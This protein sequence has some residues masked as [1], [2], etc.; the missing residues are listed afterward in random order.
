MRMRVLVMAGVTLLI[1]GALFFLYSIMRSPATP[2]TDFHS[3]PSVTTPTP[4]TTASPTPTAKPSGPKT[5]TPTATPAP[6][7]TPAMGTLTVESDVPDTSVFLDRVFLG[8]APVTAPDV[9][10]GP[11]T[12]NLSAA[13][14]DGITESV[15][16]AP[17]ART[18]SIKFKEVKL[19]ATLAVLH[20]H[21]IGSCS[22]TLH[23]TPQGLTYDTANKDDAFTTPLTNIEG[24]VFDYAQKNLRI[25]IKNG[26]TL[27]FT[28]A[29]GNVQKLYEFHR[30]VD[31]A[32]LRLLTGK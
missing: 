1:A 10:P 4:A 3:S 11:H 9:R 30:D 18:V 21:T 16:V 28:S 22:G 15:D 13:G 29:D 2:S 20:K 23:A 17:G 12:L 5:P 7:A 8:T 26:K 6:D 27:N 19:D 32:R 31:K 14:Y 25:K 24:F